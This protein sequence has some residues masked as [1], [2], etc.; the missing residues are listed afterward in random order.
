MPE[1]PGGSSAEKPKMTPRQAALAKEVNAQLP[2]TRELAVRLAAGRVLIA[3]ILHPQALGLPAPERWD[4]KERAAALRFFQ[5]QLKEF[6]GE[7]RV[8]QMSADDRLGAMMADDDDGPSGTP[9]GDTGPTAT[10]P[11][12]S[13]VPPVPSPAPG[14]KSK[15]ALPTAGDVSAAADVLYRKLRKLPPANPQ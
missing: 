2:Y 3:R 6:K 1:A 13:D 8:E 5:A 11:T 10:L 14:T 7:I 9:T 15:P 12:A 4:E